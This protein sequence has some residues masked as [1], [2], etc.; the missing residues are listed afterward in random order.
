MAIIA[1]P[2][3]DY[4]Q[5]VRVSNDALMETAVVTFEIP[6]DHDLVDAGAFK[7]WR[8]VT[9]SIPDV[10]YQVPGGAVGGALY[11]PGYVTSVTENGDEVLTVT[12]EDASAVLKRVYRQASEIGFTS[13]TEAMEVARRLIATINAGQETRRASYST[14]HDNSS[15]GERVTASAWWYFEPHDD[16]PQYERTRWDQLVA[17]G[18]PDTYA[19]AEATTDSTSG[20][21]RR[22]RVGP[23]RFASTN[24]I[25][26]ATVKIRHR[27]DSGVLWSNTLRL[28]EADMVPTN[29]GYDGESTT[30]ATY[31]LSSPLSITDE[32][33]DITTD[34]KANWTNASDV[35][36]DLYF[37]LIVEAS[38]DNANR[39]WRVYDLE[40][41]LATANVITQWPIG[42]GEVEATAMNVSP[43]SNSTL[44]SLWAW[45][46]WLREQAGLEWRVRHDPV[47]IGGAYLDLKPIV[48]S[49]ITWGA[50]EDGINV[51]RQSVTRNA[52]ERYSKVRVTTPSSPNYA[53]A[54]DNATQRE[55][56]FHEVVIDYE[57]GTPA[58][59]FASQ[60]LSE[61]TQTVLVA[62]LEIP[63]AV[64]TWSG[65]R[66]GDT[67]HLGLGR[68]PDRRWDGMVRVVARPSIEESTGRASV[69][70]VA[71][72]GEIAG[73]DG[74][75]SETTIERTAAQVK[76][77]PSLR[78]RRLGQHLFALAFR[79]NRST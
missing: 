64:N 25:T 49:A 54:T 43:P 45:L 13:A 26:K 18:N 67:V 5:T 34:V 72:S 65:L 69:T 77:T 46:E 29:A 7:D 55:I 51:K 4:T 20:T 79:D 71:V 21:L 16:F 73:S 6:A 15:A 23:F 63:R 44:K 17:D 42:V 36:N 14:A 1:T 62:Q 22:L 48:G 39:L 12:V 31:D 9:V 2:H 56:G 33:I 74:G 19:R 37:D 3:G 40:L 78:K 68:A 52:K 75:Q 76:E 11:F 8:P 57:R 41:T 50:L 66:P 32:V 30:V 59:S 35:N 70:V 58:T 28:I 38:A 61:F 53:S 47:V 10:P 24:A 60:K 27:V